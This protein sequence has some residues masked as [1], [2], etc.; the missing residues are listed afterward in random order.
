MQRSVSV[1]GWH[2]CSGKD[3]NAKGI[4][5]DFSQLDKIESDSW[6]KTAFSKLAVSEFLSTLRIISINWNY[7]QSG[8]ED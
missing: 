1:N 7:V 4:A 3:V 6:G 2:C 5:Q 8:R